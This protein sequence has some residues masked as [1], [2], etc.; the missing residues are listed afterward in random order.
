MQ[1]TILTTQRT[2]LS[3]RER[4]IA[5]LALT[6]KTNTEQAEAIN[7][8]RLQKNQLCDEEIQEVI[9]TAALFTYWSQQNNADSTKV[10]LTDQPTLTDP[11][12]YFFE[13]TH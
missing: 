7:L 13:G 8:D 10:R 4:M 5:D 12:P 6:F 3:P 9:K 2:E 1:Q 11:T